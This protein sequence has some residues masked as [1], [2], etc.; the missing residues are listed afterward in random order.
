MVYKSSY[1]EQMQR[2]VACVQSVKGT[3]LLGMFVVDVGM[4][5]VCDAFCC[6]V[7]ALKLTG[8]MTGM[9]GYPYLVPIRS[10]HNSL[11]CLAYGT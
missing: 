11:R 5:L 6:Q 2:L 10:F 7:H 4:W 3:V 8:S 9:A 1:F